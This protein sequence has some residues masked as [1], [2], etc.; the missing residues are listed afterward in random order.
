MRALITL[1]LAA[2]LTTGLEARPALNHDSAKAQVQGSYIDARTCDVWTGPCFSNS[3]INTTGELG[4]V[5]WSV[6]RGSWLGEDLSGLR[7]V[8]AIRAES[9][10]ATKGEGKVKSIVY[11]DKSASE[12]QARALV[13][14]ARRLA[15]KYISGIVKVE[16]EA[17][18]F[19]RQ[20]RSF[21]LEIPKVLK[22]R[23]RPIDTCCD[24]FCGNE[25]I[26]YP[27]LGKT[28]DFAC[29]YSMEHY[30]KGKGLGVVWSAPNARSAM[31]GK[32]AL[33]PS[34]LATK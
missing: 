10:L 34:D 26:A 4:V 33:G 28:V 8:A 14:M 24:T 11:V 15:P 13:A 16:R 25:E 32:F 7:V 23:T 22:I 3:E 2:L 18:S 17:I 27:S 31:V 9:T 30:F 20:E 5:G 6:E 1:A 19:S 21:I 12:G 29:H